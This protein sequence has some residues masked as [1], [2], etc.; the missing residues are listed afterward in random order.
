MKNRSLIVKQFIIFSLFIIIP[1]IFITSISNYAIM[2]YSEA[3]ISKSGIGEL[4]V[5][6][7]ITDLISQTISNDIINLSLNEQLNK[8]YGITDINSILNKSDDNLMLIRLLGTLSHIVE[9]NSLYSSIYINLDNF[10]YIITS[11][12]IYHK[13][14]FQDRSWIEQYLKYKDSKEPISWISPRAIDSNGIRNTYIMSYI[15]PLTPYTT[16]LRG[17]IAINIYENA[18][19]EHINSNNSNSSDNISI[20]NMNGDVI[21]HVDKSLI[22]SNISNTPYITEILKTNIN[23]GYLIEDVNGKNCLVTY[24]KSSKNGW[25]YVGV[26]SLDTLYNKVNT[27]RLNFIYIS[28]AL[29]VSGVFLSYIISRKIYNPIKKLAQQIKRVKGID[30]GNENEFTI[31]SRTFDAMIKE[32]DKL[33]RAIE[34]S[35]K[36]LRENYILS[37]LRGV[38]L[39]DDSGYDEHSDLFPFKNFICCIITIDRY[40]D[41]IEN[42]SYENQYYL[43]TA[44]LNLSQE[45]LGVP[46]VCEG[47]VMDGNKIV[48]IVNSDDKDITQEYSLLNGYFQTIQ[49][50]AAKVIETTI[51]VCIGNIYDN[52]HKVR[53]SY[54]E[55]QSLLNHK[56]ILGYEKVLFYGKDFTDSNSKYYYPFTIEKQ[57]LN[58]VDVGSKEA[59][60]ASVNDFINEIKN[61]KELSYDN[62]MLILNQLLGSIIKYLLNLNISVSKIFG[63]D[64]NI[65]SKLADIETLDETGLFLA[66]VFLQIIEYCEKIKVDDTSHIAKIMDYIHKNYKQ[67]IAINTLA[68]Y[69]GLSYSHV[70]KIFNDATGENIVNYINNMRIEEAQRLLRQT[71]MSINDIALSLGYN[72]K[73]S[74]N[75]FFKKYVSINPGEYR[76]I[77]SG[78]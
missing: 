69:V 14:D 54:H 1:V 47:I 60:L 13:D 18:L 22:S 37:L 24:Y 55:A 68:D 61:N 76:N 51:T 27:L 57:I 25:I 21:S 66:N 23:E 34:K 63:N 64:F 19:C 2:K 43:K 16:K 32:E 11:N 10:D 74:F 40:K 72:N 29:L 77:K 39:S 70:R 78:L 45:I 48:I 31:L 15:F 36:N 53:T 5:A 49:K 58:N 52:I 67:D 62:T 35:K 65:Y 56:F 30:F 50:E 42:F 41:F 71:N 75:R 4:K 28:I 8:L 6:E 20:I 26:F 9:T 46:F 73:Q 3:E 12:G 7:N 38:P 59:V 17:S 33:F 44:I